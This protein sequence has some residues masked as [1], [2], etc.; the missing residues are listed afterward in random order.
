MTRTGPV[1]ASILLAWTLLS[2]C[3]DR[4]PATLKDARVKMGTRFSIQLVA[5]DAAAGRSAIDAAYDEIDRVEA[6]LSEWKDD[7]EIT[8]LNRAAGAGAQAV[9]VELFEVLARSIEI[10]ERTGGAFDVTFA[11]CGSL[12]SFSDPHIPSRSELDDCVRNTG[13]RK[14]E[15]DEVRR[16]VTLPRGMRIGIAGIGKGYGVDRAAGLLERHGFDRYIVD[17]GGDVRLSGTNV[18]QPWLVGVAHPR[19]VGGLLGSLTVERGAIVTSGDYMSYFERDGRRYH[20]ILDPA[21]GQ[22]ARGSVAVTVI[23]PTVTDADALATALFVL[24]PERA[25]ELLDSIPNTEA[26]IIDPDLRQH[27]SPGF[28]DLN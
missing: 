17:G 16:S 1:V 26:L 7:S 9:G 27:R 19:Q 20:H 28:P 21:T 23:A 18:D 13:Y 2:G 3:N 6:L 25:L 22:P 8:A 24:G 5:D 10:S 12:W 15:L 11:A 14:L 4:A